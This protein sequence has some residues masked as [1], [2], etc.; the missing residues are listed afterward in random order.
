MKKLSFLLLF[1]LILLFVGCDAPV[2]ERDDK[3][4]EVYMVYTDWAESVA[5]TYLS[6]VLL[7]EYLGYDVITRLTDIETVFADVAAGSADVFV[8]VWVPH[9]HAPFLE[10]YAGQFEDLGPNYYHARAGL[11]VP[12]YMPVESIPGLRDL[13]DQPIAG[14]DTSAGVMRNT[15]KALLAYDLDNELLV[16]SDSG[17]AEKLGEAIRRREPI[18]VTGWMPHWLMYRYDLKFLDDP[19]NIFMEQEQIHTIARNGFA[20]DMPRA[21]ELL[22]RIVLSQ[23]H[24]NSLLYT[25]HR[26]EDPLDGVKEWIRDN[27]SMVNRWVRGLAP[28][29]EKIM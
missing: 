1:A 24:I 13:Y 28:A 2:R 4:T 9:T 12:G 10:E 8:D 23:H 14:I 17:M 26:S 19:L 7:E 25:I 22:K 15:M 5:L 27:Q 20:D 3:D 18:V 21:A 6:R 11:V 29:R 16:L